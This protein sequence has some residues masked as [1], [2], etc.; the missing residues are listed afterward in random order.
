MYRIIPFFMLFT[1]I[2][3][4]CGYAQNTI[5]PYAETKGLSAENVPVVIKINPSELNVLSG[6][7]ASTGANLKKNIRNYMYLWTGSVD[8]GPYSFKWNVKVKEPGSYD[9][10]A[11]VA[12]EDAQLTL[13]CNEKVITQAGAQ[14]DWS[15]IPLGVIKLNKDINQIEI[16]VQATKEVK[17]AGIELTQPK[18]KKELKQEALE[19]RNEPDWFKDA[20]YGLMFQWTNRATPKQGNTVKDWED[21]INDFDLDGFVDLVEQSGAAYVIWSI[22]WGQQY[23]SAPIQSLEKLIEGRTTQRD[24]LG[25]MADRLAEKDIK[26][27]F[28][29]HYGYDCYHS[30]DSAWLKVAGGYLEDKT[31]LYQNIMNIVSE[32]GERYGNKLHGWFFDGGRRYYDS[33]FDGASSEGILSAPFK[34]IT[35]AA[36]TGNAKRIIAY[37]SWI[38]P[39]STEFQDYYAGE[40]LQQ[41]T[42]LDEGVF[43]N[44]KHKGLMAHTCFP[45]EKRWGHIEWNKEITSPKYSVEQLVEYIRHAQK[46]RYPLSINL[47]MYEDGTVSPESVD[48]LTKVRT[49]IREE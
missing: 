8:S 2:F 11:I 5:D 45:L 30:K 4:F 9:V 10:T 49:I 29:Y 36:R 19:M 14:H 16:K 38:L 44:G 13:S 39:R 18:V 35:Q 33:H 24:L 6:I 21:K 20:G 17:L 22:T 47:E 27:I 46:N 3:S 32:V 37:N 31:Q 23:I 42:A 25:E 34:A 28:Y 26:L 1:L 7:N 41:F 48:L 15:R 12:G 43:S 40:G